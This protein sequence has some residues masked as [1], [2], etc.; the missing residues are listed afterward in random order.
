M[1]RCKAANVAVRSLYDEI[2]VR[3]VAFVVDYER[4]DDLRDSNFLHCR[5]MR[6]SLSFVRS[7]ITHHRPRIAMPIVAQTKAITSTTLAAARAVCAARFPLAF[8]TSALSVIYIYIYNC[9]FVC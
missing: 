1:R 9:L 2:A 7:N 4:D 5:E 6:K 8:P 3:S